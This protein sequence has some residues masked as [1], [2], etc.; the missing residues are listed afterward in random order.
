L[1]ALPEINQLQIIGQ[2]HFLK[3]Q[4]DFK[5]VRRSKCLKGNHCSLSLFI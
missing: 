3:T 5:I 1:F 2:P 4:Q